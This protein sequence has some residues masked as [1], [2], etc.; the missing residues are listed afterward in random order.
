MEH[1][2][3]GQELS[4][5]LKGVQDKVDSN[6]ATPEAGKEVQA[7]AE[8]QEEQKPLETPEDKPLEEMLEDEEEEKEP[9]APE[10][11]EDNKEEPEDEPEMVP[12]AT[13]LKV[14]KDLKAEIR[15]LKGKNY[16]D[17]DIEDVSQEVAEQYDVSPDFVK[18]LFAR[19]LTL[20]E[21]RFKDQLQEISS[22]TK[23]KELETKKEKLFDSIFEGLV[24]KNPNL[25][26]I[27]NKDFIKSQA[28]DPKNSKK[29]VKQI[30]TEI[31][32]KA[33]KTDSEGFDGYTPHKE[34]EKPNTFNPTVED[35]KEIKKNPKLREEFAQNL[36]KNI[37]W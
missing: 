12:K 30:I 23:E 6:K 11:P 4:K 9:E 35:M 5:I 13:L 15:R 2:E 34:V 21:K 16:N 17:S 28:L 26:E 31:Y 14:K 22:K 3:K 29:S 37:R 7:E 20:A 36:I 25:K 18:D 24:S 32:G 10:E 8:P 27:V 1:E 33:T 19:S